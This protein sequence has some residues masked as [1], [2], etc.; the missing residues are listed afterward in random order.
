MFTN[1]T[2]EDFKS[3]FARDFPYSNNCD[4][5]I[6]D[7]DIQKALDQVAY[8]INDSLF[9]DQTE[10]NIGYFLLSAHYLCMNIRASS[11]GLG[12]N[13]EWLLGSKS[14]G[15]ISVS[16]SIPSSILED[17]ILAYYSSTGYGA[18]YLI[19][20]YPKIMGTIFAVEGGTTA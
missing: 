9:C 3:Y 7:S 4:D 19:M 10:Y 16:Q 18:E 13:F 11:Q 5:G 20:I 8:K 14:V 12:S 15:S 2:V 6:L 1:P 17:P